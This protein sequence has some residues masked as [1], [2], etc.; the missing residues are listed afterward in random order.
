[1]PERFVDLSHPLQPATPPWPG[2]P[3]M[4]VQVLDAIDAGQPEGQPT[5]DCPGYLNA[6]CFSTCNHTGTHMDAP[7]HFF[8]GVHT[9]DRVPLHRCIGPCTRIRLHACPPNTTIHP[10]DLEPAAEAARRTGKL[11]I[12]TGWAAHWGARDYFTAYPVLSADAAQWLVETGLHLV[13]IDT[14]AVDHPPHPAHRIL[15]GAEALIIENL[16]NLEAL[17]VDVF[18]LIATPLPLQGLEASPIRAVARL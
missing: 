1:M 9:I 17:D 5:P 14:P 7:A 4:R 16:T 2:N 13:G 15:L 18:E 10:A 8:N 12:D 3:P 11:L 6:T